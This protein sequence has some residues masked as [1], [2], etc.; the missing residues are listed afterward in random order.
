M[1]DLLVGAAIY[2]AGVF[3]GAFLYHR[4]QVGLPP[5]PDL[6]AALGPDNDEPKP[7]DESEREPL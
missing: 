4:K 5:L 3:T 7:R 1:I 6:V 2:A